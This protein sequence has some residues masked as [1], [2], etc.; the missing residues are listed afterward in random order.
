MTTPNA[1][2]EYRPVELMKN[3]AMTK[4]DCKD[5]VAVWENFVPKSFCDKMIKYFDHVYEQNG[6]Y[7]PASSHDEELYSDR[8]ISRG[9]DYYGGSL[10]RKDLSLMINYTDQK[11][12]Y[13]INQFLKAC[14]LHY[15][16]EFP[17]LK[18][19]NLMSTDI[20]MQ[21][22]PP[23]GG[24]HLWHYENAD[25]YH[26]MRELTWMIYLN[27]LPDG[28]GETEFLYQKRRIKPTQGTVVIF[29]AGLTHVHRG[30]TVLT[31]D[32]YILTGWYF[33]TA[34]S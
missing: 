23:G 17:Q 21:K 15:V 27:D 30:N 26:S 4:Y 19:A 7:I 31:T 3:P 9:E 11:L 8:N 12:S 29:P 32:K 14:A 33:K 25:I 13:E 20:K 24:Y 2:Q 18:F 10:S 16:D 34:R 5:F 6:C 22:T 1:V 28:E